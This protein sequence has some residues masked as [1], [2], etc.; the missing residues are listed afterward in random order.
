[1]INCPFNPDKRVDNTPETE[2]ARKRIMKM[3]VDKYGPVVV[4]KVKK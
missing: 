3:F 4:E 2:N 1:L